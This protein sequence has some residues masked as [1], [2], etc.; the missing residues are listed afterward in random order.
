MTPLGLWSF[1]VSFG[2]RV[3]PNAAGP[4]FLYNHQ[5]Q[6]GEREMAKIKLLCLI[7]GVF[8]LCLAGRA[9]AAPPAA[10]KAP[11]DS[12]K[13]YRLT[14][15]F[16]GATRSLDTYSDGENAPFMDTTSAATGQLWKFTPLKDGYYRLTNQ[17]LG[18]KRSLDTYADEGNAPF[19]GETG[20]ATGQ[21]WKLTPVEVKK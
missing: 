19:M 12:S 9:S 7:V 5:T 4:V 3:L 8:G 18:A 15:E 20:E 6:R 21:A 17:F 16:L 10:V 2:E 14:N 13:W 11:V 1:R